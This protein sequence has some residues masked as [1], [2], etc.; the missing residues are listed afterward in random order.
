MHNR[1]SLLNTLVFKIQSLRII[2]S[3]DAQCSIMD[4]YSS[5]LLVAYSMIAV[6]SNSKAQ[7]HKSLFKNV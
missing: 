7:M 5:R 2:S 1:I 4:I 3:K 6:T